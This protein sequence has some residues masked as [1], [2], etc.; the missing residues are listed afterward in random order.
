MKKWHKYLV[1]I[2][3]VGA[4]I[5]GSYYILN[6]QKVQTDKS[7]IQ[8]STSF[9]PLY[10]FTTQIGGDKAEVRNITPAGAEPHDYEPTAQE[11]AGIE[12]SQ[13]LVLNG[14]VE[15]WGSKIQDQLDTH[16][17]LVVLA[18][19]DLLNIDL[20]EDG[21]TIKDPHVWLDPVLAKQEANRILAGFIQ[22]DPQNQTYYESNA[23]KLLTELDQINTE[24]KAGLQKCNK[25]DIVTTHVA[26]AYLASEYGLK[27][28]AIAGVSPDEEPSTQKLAEVA[29]FVRANNIKYIFFETLISPKLAETIAQETGA[30][31]MVLD[32]LEGIS[33]KDAQS[34]ANYVS[35]MRSNLKNLQI[36]LECTQ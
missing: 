15:A 21:N 29:D 12:D 25:K 10:F 7:K 26:F 36:A 18:G 32:P 17:T 4:V 1:V 5:A 19:K 14:G 33:D 9:Y 30:Q 16:K 20:V 2:L 23:N 13:M 24:Y 8:V 35:V 31:T 6:H 28:I 22:I 3:L 27:Q 34:G 11:I